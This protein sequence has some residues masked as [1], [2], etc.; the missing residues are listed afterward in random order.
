LHEILSRMAPHQMVLDLGSGTHG[1]FGD[2]ECAA[3]SIHCDLT[4]E[5][6]K[7]RY[8]VCADAAFLPFAAESFDAIVL[9]HSLEHFP[10]PALVLAELKRILRDGGCLWVAVP[11]AS[12]LS[13][14]IYRWVSHGGGHVNQ[15]VDLQALLGFIE[16]ETG[17]ARAGVRLLFS[18]YSFLNRNNGSRGYGRRI[19]LFGG[20]AEWWLSLLTLTCRKFDR[21]FG[22]RASL[23]G[24]G[25]YF[26]SVPNS[27]AGTF[28]NVCI[29]CGTGHSS[30]WL[31]EAGRVYR[32]AFRLQAF[33]CPKCG[34]KNFFTRDEDYARGARCVA[35]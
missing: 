6:T 10:H 27:D 28:T 13:D 5:K 1:S 3:V 23:Y 31:M 8:F 14:R 35:D 4:Q 7:L 22:T 34:A 29:R 11:D 30:S 17:L 9:N 15:F 21:C 18:S 2:G 16:S 25:C 12:T 19:Y 20:G 32:N 33:K 24:W 26:G